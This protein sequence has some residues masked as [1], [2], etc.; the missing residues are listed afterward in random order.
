MRVHK[1]PWRRRLGVL[2]GIASLST[3]VLAAPAHADKLAD[4][5]A[6]KKAEAARLAAAVEA[7]GEKV[8]IL[9][10]KLNQARLRADQVQAQVAAAKAE[11][12]RTDAVVGQRREELKAYVIQAF[13]KGGNASSLQMLMSSKDSPS[14]LAIRTSYVKAVTAQHRTALDELAA[15][16]EAAD[17]KRA[18]LEAAQKDSRSA[19]DAVNKDRR[20]AEDATR[21]AQATLDQVKGE[22]SQLVAAEAQRRAD[23]AARRA[24][25]DLAARQTRPAATRSRPSRSSA[26]TGVDPGPAPAP[27]PGAAAAVAEAKR[28][29]G[30]PY[31]YGAAGPGSFDCSGLTMWSWRAGGVSLPHSS[32]AQYSA[33]SRVAVSALQPGDLVFYGSPIHHV[34][35]YVGNGTMVEASHEGVPVRY[36]SIYRSDLVGAGRVG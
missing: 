22:L 16:R 35:I 9:A 14:N 1:T 23:E 20:A 36:A 32:S 30:K 7:Q 13:M 10:E 25:A 24:Q 18:R 3:G 29:I 11:V 21:T 8:S 19:L 33:T 31:Q 6:D 4:K 34:G 17:A 15:A 28:Q 26:G 27:N 12:A 2:V 5:L